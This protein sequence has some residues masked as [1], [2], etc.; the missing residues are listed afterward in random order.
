MDLHHQIISE[1]FIEYESDELSQFIVKATIYRLSNTY[2]ELEFYNDPLNKW[3]SK[4][5]EEITE[6]F[7]IINKIMNRRNLL[8]VHWK[9]DKELS[10]I[11]N[12]RSDNVN[13][14][15]IIIFCDVD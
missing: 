15:D 12:G 7:A 2:I 10:D 11:Q 5:C 14:L 4:I 3:D 1:A 6:L 9:N 13:Y 8:V